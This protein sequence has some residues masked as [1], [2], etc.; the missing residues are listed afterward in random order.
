[1][2]RLLGRKLN[3][4][5]HLFLVSRIGGST[6]SPVSLDKMTRGEVCSDFRI[7]HLLDGVGH[8]VPQESPNE[9]V[10]MI[11]EFVKELER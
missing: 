5:V 7:L 2:I 11:L 10:Q 1:M 9:V 6:K 4:R 3:V 8:W